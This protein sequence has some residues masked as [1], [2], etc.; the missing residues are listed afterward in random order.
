M[1]WYWY[2]EVIFLFVKIM[3]P[4]KNKPVKQKFKVILITVIKDLMIM[5]CSIYG[6][7]VL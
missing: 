1:N 6:C 3:L 7:C 5:C 4:V 2:N